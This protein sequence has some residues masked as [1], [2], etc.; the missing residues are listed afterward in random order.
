MAD[1]N[2]NIVERV[3]RV[4]FKKYTEDFDKYEFWKLFEMELKKLEDKLFSCEI[5]LNEFIYKVKE[6]RE[7]RDTYYC[8]RAWKQYLDILVNFDDKPWEKHVLTM[9][10]YR[11]LVEMVLSY[12]REYKS[13]EFLDECLRKADGERFRF[14]T[15]VLK[16]L[17]GNEEN[18]DALIAGG[19]MLRL[20][21][22]SGVKPPELEIK[23]EA[24]QSPTVK[25]R[26]HEAEILRKGFGDVDLYVHVSKREEL[27]KIFGEITVKD[28]SVRSYGISFFRKNGIIARALLK[29]IDIDIMLVE[30]SPLE[31]V[32][33]F[34]LTCCEV[35]FNG[36]NLGASKPVET[37]NRI[38]YLRKE[39]LKSLIEGNK[40]INR[41]I[42]KYSELGFRIFVEDSTEIIP[43]HDDK[44]K[45]Y[46]VRRYGRYLNN[47]EKAI[48]F[49][50]E[51]QVKIIY[52]KRDIDRYGRARGR[53]K[54]PTLS[55]FYK[56]VFDEELPQDFLIGLTLILTGHYVIGK[57]KYDK[58][59]RGE[60][61]VREVNYRK[62]N[63]TRVML[64]IYCQE[65]LNIPGITKLVESYIK[66]YVPYDFQTVKEDFMNQ[67]RT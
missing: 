40:F 66:N 20:F 39:Y 42:K 11:F 6:E 10:K 46:L 64:A 1:K 41:R 44:R 55:E 17:N 7:I 3:K 23:G 18:N 51:K 47:V 33:N 43:E 34:D 36:W 29:D 53:G 25:I 57:G 31:V 24:V 60:L 52:N 16:R 32:N 4:L 45:R 56:T 9:S 30:K 49:E 22:E 65:K 13:V 59:L 5:T 8:R 26:K 63:A 27:E 21:A 12:G 2:K 61:S 15:D 35:W 14:L 54:K 67:Q 58:L 37:L 38:S 48:D 19:Y 50:P 28:F 62:P